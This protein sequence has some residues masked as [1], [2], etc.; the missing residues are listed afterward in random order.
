MNSVNPGEKLKE[1]LRAVI[2]DAEALLR[3]TGGQVGEKVQQARAKAE[4]SIRA[5]RERL[6]ALEDEIAQR[7]RDAAHDTDRYVRDNPWQALAITAGAAF[8]VGLILGRR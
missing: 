5:A 1:D 4:E 6:G 3:A 7:A 2:E 8:L